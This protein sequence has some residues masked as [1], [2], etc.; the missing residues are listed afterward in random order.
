MDGEICTLRGSRTCVKFCCVP[1]LTVFLVFILSYFSYF[2]SAF[3][4][5]PPPVNAS[6]R[7]VGVLPDKRGEQD[8]DYLNDPGSKQEDVGA[9]D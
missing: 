8:P 7:R 4:L 3:C 6:S 5:Y 2:L 9:G 1:L